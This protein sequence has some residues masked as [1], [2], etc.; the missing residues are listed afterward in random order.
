MERKKLA[1]LIML[2][3]LWIIA[4]GNQFVENV[5]ANP[6][7]LPPAPQLSNVYIRSD[8]NVDPP[9]LPIINEGTVYTFTDDIFNFTLKIQCSNIV[10]NGAGHM[11]QGNGTGKGIFISDENKITIKDLR[12]Q[13]FATAIT[14]SE[15][16]HNSI[17]GNEITRSG[18]GITIRLSSNN[19]IQNNTVA[20]NG[21][22]LLFYDRCDYNQI[23]NNE[24]NSNSDS[25]IW[26]EGTVPGTSDYISII[27]NN[28]TKNKR[29]GVLLRSSTNSRLVGN[30]IS[31]NKWGIELYGDA[32]RDCLITENNIGYNEDGI[33]LL[34]PYG[35]EIYHNNFFKNSRQVY[36]TSL[37]GI[38]Y[39]W[40]FDEK[41]NYWSDY[42]GTDADGN[43][44]GDIP[45]IIN[46]ENIDNYP[47]IFP[48]IPIINS[49]Q[50][51]PL[52]SK[53]PTPTNVPSSIPTLEPTPTPTSTPE[54]HQ[55]L[56][57]PSSL[58]AVIIIIVVVLVLGLTIY[59]I[60]KG[61]LR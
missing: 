11:L 53:S 47:L 33:R 12:L 42:N 48:A 57:L 7:H 8:G 25:G 30:T 22:G 44:I 17:I 55:S 61:D 34:C 28:I 6:T 23:I 46:E 16:S 60:K 31:Q 14:L 35:S 21:Q 59:L 36:R 24:I 1:A 56:Q 39:T 5:M 54:L 2:I 3:V 52:T 18:T 45:Y 27:G 40:E 13:R 37:S 51:S 4:T 15:S 9:T 49:P 32:S 29:W 58:E 50:L 19:L 41:G 20:S 26:C 38:P 43:G 10:V